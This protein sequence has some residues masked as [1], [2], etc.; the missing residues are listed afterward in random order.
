MSREQAERDLTF[1]GFAVFH[2]PMKENSTEA[3]RI[4]SASSH[5]VRAAACRRGTQL[6]GL[7]QIDF[8]TVC[9]YYGGQ[10]SHSLQGYA[11]RSV[12]K[13]IDLYLIMSYMRNNEHV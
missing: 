9:H 12:R 11:A 7:F 10:C 4:L 13:E 1:A 3:I 8:T 5:K 6:L 2:C